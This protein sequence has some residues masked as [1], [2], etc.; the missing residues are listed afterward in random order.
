MVMRRFPGNVSVQLL[1]AERENLA[2]VLW[3]SYAQ[4]KGQIIDRKRHLVIASPHPS[5]LSASRGFFGS[6]P[7]S[8]INRYLEATGRTPI[9]WALPPMAGA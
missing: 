5:P 2:F 6:K 9:D 8:K 4:K 3:G 1:S 7:F